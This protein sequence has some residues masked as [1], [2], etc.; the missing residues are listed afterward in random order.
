MSWKRF[1]AEPASVRSA[2]GNA[3]REGELRVRRLRGG[4]RGSART[5][6]RGGVVLGDPRQSSFRPQCIC[7]EDVDA[8]S[9]MEILLMSGRKIES[10]IRGGCLSPDHVLLALR[11]KTNLGFRSPATEGR[12][13]FSNRFVCVCVCVY[14]H[15][16]VLSTY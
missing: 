9:L 3:Y 16:Y 2:I 11:H 4:V 13:I 6:R 12:A 5:A 14:I 1:I 15:V 8:R 10:G 7:N